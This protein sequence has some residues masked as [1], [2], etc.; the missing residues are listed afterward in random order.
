[1]RL[2]AHDFMGQSANRS[3]SLDLQNPIFLL[4]WHWSVLSLISPHIPGW[5]CHCLSYV[6]RSSANSMPSFCFV[7]ARTGTDMQPNC[8]PCSLVGHRCN[9]KGCISNPFGDFGN[10]TRHPGKLINPPPRRCGALGKL[11]TA[12]WRK[13]LQRLF[14]SGSF[15]IHGLYGLAS[16]KY[17]EFKES[18]LAL[19]RRCLQTFWRCLTS[20]TRR[21]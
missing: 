3:Q 17:I 10:P 12:V 20:T 7:R 11:S 6:L 5:L 14:D 2:E 19:F 18:T 9:P 4:F 15:N 8:W 16:L 1:M 21:R 13:I